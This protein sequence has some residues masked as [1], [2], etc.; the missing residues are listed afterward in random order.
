MNVITKNE[1]FNT[2]GN[3]LALLVQQLISEKVVRKDRT[4]HVIAVGQY[5]RVTASDVRQSIIS[6]G[7][8]Q[9]SWAYNIRLDM[10]V[11]NA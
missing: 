4:G 8:R 2:F 10:F 6:L 1:T 7:D 5:E 11:S 9:D 3:I